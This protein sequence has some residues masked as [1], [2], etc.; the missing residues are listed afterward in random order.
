MQNHITQQSAGAAR[1]ETNGIIETNQPFVSDPP[2]RSGACSRTPTSIAVTLA[3][4]GAIAGLAGLA[5]CASAPPPT[6][7]MAVAEASVQRASTASTSE[8][9][10]AS[11]QIA[12]S[13]LASARTAMNN[14]DYDLAKQL[15]EEAE[16]DSQVA[17]LRAQSARSSKAAQESNAAARA[18]REELERKK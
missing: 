3:F 7:Q 4:A 6:A 13:K 10:A 17:E 11:L 5:G 14:K 16:V 18:L 1:P 12:V 8:N 9:A 15:A 2:Y